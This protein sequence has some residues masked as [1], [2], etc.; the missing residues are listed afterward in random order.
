MAVITARDSAV[1]VEYDS[2]GKRVAK[3]FA[4]ANEAKKF[5]VRKDRSGHNPAIK[6]LPDKFK[7]GDRP[8]W[9]TEQVTIIGYADRVHSGPHIFQMWR[10]WRPAYTRK[11]DSVCP[12]REQLIADA[13]LSWKPDT[14]LDEM[15]NE[16]I[17]EGASCG[18]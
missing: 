15:V 2:R 1:M 4:V 17:E 9:F 8:Y 16:F 14:W 18:H 5:F 7:V 12:A 3:Y 13:W 6:P 11:D 10:C